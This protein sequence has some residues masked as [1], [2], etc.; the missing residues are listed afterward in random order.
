[1]KTMRDT[2]KAIRQIYRRMLMERSGIERLRM[3]ARLSEMM[4]SF[5]TAG[6]AAQGHSGIALKVELAKRLYGRELDAGTMAGLIASLE[7]FR[8]RP[9][10]TDCRQ[11]PQET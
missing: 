11:P 2:P 1:M 7:R 10:R 5:A 8:P 4:V 6:L 9:D 3:G